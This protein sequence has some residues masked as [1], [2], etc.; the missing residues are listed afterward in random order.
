MNG[1]TNGNTSV[2][3]NYIAGKFV[4]P[5]TGEYLDV[6][7]PGDFHVIAKVGVSN[8]ADVDSAIAAAEA[9]LPAWSGLTVK[10]RAAMVS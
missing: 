3:D 10:A 5:S 6:A 4:A 7:N 8:K 2:V 9:A 1:T